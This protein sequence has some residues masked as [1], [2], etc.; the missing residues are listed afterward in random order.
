MIAL[1]Q[2]IYNIKLH[3]DLVGKLG[4]QKII[5]TYLGPSLPELDS[6]SILP[7][8]NI[9]AFLLQLHVIIISL[10]LL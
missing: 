10:P 7:L 2:K 5:S 8:P 4:F 6:S 3:K 9:F 1:I